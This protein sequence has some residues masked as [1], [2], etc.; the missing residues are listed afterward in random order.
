[1]ATRDLSTTYSRLR[2][3]HRAAQLSV[4]SPSQTRLR[5]QLAT[6]VAAP[7]YASL[8]EALRTEIDLMKL[9]VRDLVKSHAERLKIQFDEAKQNELDEEINDLA[10][11]IRNST[12]LCENYIKQVASKDN[13]GHLI[14]QER[15]IRA[16]IMRAVGAEFNAVTQKFQKEQRKFLELIQQQGEK[17]GKHSAQNA[18]DQ[19]IIDK[20]QRGEE[21]T[22]EQ[23]AELTT[24]QAHST[25]RDQK[26]IQLAQSI[27]EL[28]TLF[29]QLNALVIEQGT[30][31]D[32]VDHNVEASLEH[33]KEG[34]KN[35]QDAE[36]TSAKMIT[37]KCIGTLLMVIV[38]L[39]IILVIKNSA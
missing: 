8:V 4:E 1:M 15:I 26:I 24:M 27:N 37:T 20:V 16:N 34:R 2:S 13:T 18:V 29:Q 31:L 17:E 9:K 35:V 11:D 38:V 28:A 19:E 22:S 33:V 3:A 23:Q 7:S 39:F 10:T 12:K 32:R 30:I 6:P 5:Q 21:L 36:E 25:E 14:Q